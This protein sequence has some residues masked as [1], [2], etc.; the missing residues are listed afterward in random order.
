MGIV[1]GGGVICWGHK[2]RGGDCSMVEPQVSGQRRVK[3][4]HSTPCAF[5][6]V[7]DDNSIVTWG[8]RECGGDSSSVHDQLSSHRPIEGVYNTSSA[9]LAVVGSSRKSTAALVSG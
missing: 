7:M 4:I 5:A 9:F 2:D 6:A 8:H 3:S 1:E